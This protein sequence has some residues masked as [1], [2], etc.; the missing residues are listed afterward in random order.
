MPFALYSDSN[1]YSLAD[2]MSALSAQGIEIQGRE[3]SLS[4]MSFASEILSPLINPLSDDS[5]S[6]ESSVS[7]DSLTSAV[8]RHPK[9]YNAAD[10]VAFTQSK[11]IRVFPTQGEVVGP[12]AL[13][14]AKCTEAIVGPGYSLPITLVVE[15]DAPVVTTAGTSVPTIA[16]VPAPVAVP[17]VASVPTP[18]AVPAVASVPAPVAVPAITSVPTS[19]AVPAVAS[20]PAPVAVPTV[21]SVPAPVA[22]PAVASVPAPV[23]VLTV[24]PLPAVASVPAPVQIPTVPPVPAL[25]AATFGFGL[26]PVTS[27]FIAPAGPIPAAAQA[28]MDPVT[29]Q[30]L[31]CY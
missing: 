23:A 12:T 15:D 24:A 9:A 16:P 8:S 26:G 31:K 20:V 4:G 14:C 1:T 7:S 5:S 30:A 17:A 18:V 3:I 29:I 2:V 13:I 19:V 6:D 28:M 11:T 21:A 10:F 22:V 25:P 27:N